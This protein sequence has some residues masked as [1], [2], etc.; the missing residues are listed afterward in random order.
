MLN[1]KLELWSVILHFYKQAPSVITLLFLPPPFLPKHYLFIQETLW[2]PFLYLLSLEA[3]LFIPTFIFFNKLF[4]DS[5]GVFNADNNFISESYVA[6]KSSVQLPILPSAAL[7]ICQ[8]VL[9]RMVRRQSMLLFRHGQE[10]LPRAHSAE[11]ESGRST[12]RE[13]KENSWLLEILG[14]PFCFHH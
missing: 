12:V 6:L 7:L 11:Q 14:S 3:L 4:S 13:F 5:I 2:L 1:A 10:E 9:C 8:A